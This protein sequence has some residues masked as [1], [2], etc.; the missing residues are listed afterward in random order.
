VN[1]SSY[2]RIRNFLTVMIG[3]SLSGVLIVI[4]LIYIYGP[5]DTYKAK[6]V[7]LS[8]DV[9]QKFWYNTSSA[10]TKGKM[11]RFSIKE[12]ELLYFDKGSS[13]YTTVQVPI[14]KYGAF[15]DL[16]KGDRGKSQDL[17]LQQQ[18]DE[19]PAA[20]ILIKSSASGGNSR[21]V[22]EI[23][24]QIQFSQG[25]NTYRVELKE[26]DKSDSWVYFTH[27]DIT[28]KVMKIFVPHS[29]NFGVMGSFGAAKDAK[30]K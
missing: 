4:A 25:A 3:G 16:V 7:L 28:N 22:T 6:N 2:T 21:T 14:L 19:T 27:D 18:F 15:Y 17:A 13:R 20:T 9:L 30:I 8:P 10:S 24:Q 12:I 23:F 26:D 5:T 11:S 29:A 1:E